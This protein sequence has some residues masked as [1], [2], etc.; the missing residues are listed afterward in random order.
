MK[1]MVIG[2]GVIR[3]AGPSVVGQPRNGCLSGVSSTQRAARPIAIGILAL[4]LRQFG[5]GGI[6]NKESNKFGIGGRD[7]TVSLK[8][9]SKLERSN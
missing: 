1:S 9:I 2:T 7:E 8:R 5:N 4:I 6:W 3:M